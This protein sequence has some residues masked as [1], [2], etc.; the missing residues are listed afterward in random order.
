M[1]AAMKSDGAPPVSQSPIAKQAVWPG[2]QL[3]QQA[4]DYWVDAW[5][6]SVLFLDVM[7][8]R[9]NNYFERAADS[10]PNLLH[11]QFEP[12]MNGRDLPRRVNYGLVRILPPAAPTS[13]S[14]ATPTF[15]SSPTSRLATCSPTS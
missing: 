3:A 13:R 12:V 14:T 11:F 15:C 7:R 9:G 4:C 1:I 6:R 8:Q 2:M 10:V 5:Q